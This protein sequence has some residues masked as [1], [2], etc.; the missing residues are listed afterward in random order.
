[1]STV[2]LGSG[3]FSV[4]NQD[5]RSLEVCGDRQKEWRKTEM[6]KGGCGFGLVKSG[7]ELMQKEAINCL[8]SNQHSWKQRSIVYL[9]IASN[10]VGTDKESGDH[11]VKIRV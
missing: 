4:E 5:Q 9:V 6:I 7:D 10:T 3:M 2:K 8:S 1:M 11:K